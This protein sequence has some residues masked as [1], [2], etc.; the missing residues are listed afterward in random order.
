MGRKIELIQQKNFKTFDEGFDEFIMMC[1]VKN[2]RPSTIKQYETIINIWYKFVPYK[3]PIKDIT[4]N[5]VNAFI[6]FLKNETNENDVTINSV[7]VHVRVVLYYFMKLGYME[8]FKIPKMKVDKE[9]IET[10]TDEE[11]KIL[12]QKPNI[13]KCSYLEYRNWIIINFL[14]ATGCRAG[15][16]VNIKIIDVDFLN[17]LITYTHTKNRKQQ[18]IPL[19]NTLKAIL[20]EYLQYRKG[21]LEDYLF[22]NAYGN[23]LTTDQLS[24]N[25]SDYN[26]KRGVIKTGIH[27]FRHTFAK[28]WIMQG[29]DIFRLQKILG[30]SSMDIVKNYV[31]IFTNDLQQDFNTFNPLENLQVNKKHISIKSK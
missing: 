8:E 20:I 14:M 16:L 22:V 19:S 10:Y 18:I 27:R 5:T 26:K 3:T 1:K 30:H 7:I 11:L 29:G 9:I 15:T 23:Y 31:N 13:K 12:L 17:D 25:I 28:K 21:G 24:H 6:M 2:L 4:K